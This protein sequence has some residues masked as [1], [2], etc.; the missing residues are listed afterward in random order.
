MRPG[1]AGIPGNEAADTAAK[2]ARD[3]PATSPK[4]LTVAHVVAT[5]GRA[6]RD[7]ILRWASSRAYTISILLNITNPRPKKLFMPEVIFPYQL[8]LYYRSLKEAVI[9]T[10]PLLSSPRFFF[11]FFLFLPKHAWPV[12]YVHL[13]RALSSL[14]K[15]KTAHGFHRPPSPLLPA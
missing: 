6:R 8:S 1:H 14:L 9:H 7:L 11:F 10:R 2:E 4:V 15:T 12:C 5:S 13:K 3:R